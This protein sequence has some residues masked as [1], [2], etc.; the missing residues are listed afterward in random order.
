[1]SEETRRYALSAAMELS[2]RLTG[3]TAASEVISMAKEIEDYL[4]GRGVSP[5]FES[6]DGLESI[7]QVSRSGRSEPEVGG[8]LSYVPSSIPVGGKIY[9]LAHSHIHNAV[10]S[11]TLTYNEVSE[12]DRGFAGSDLVNACS[13]I[14]QGSVGANFAHS[15]SSSVVADGESGDSVAADPRNDDSADTSVKGGSGDA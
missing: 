13:D 15:S 8:S 14:S 4:V 12:D 3:F 7:D 1:M 6:Q 5:L 11:L 9:R 2:G 10:C